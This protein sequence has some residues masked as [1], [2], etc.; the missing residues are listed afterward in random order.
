L[1]LVIV[2]EVTSAKESF[3]KAKDDA[4]NVGFKPAV[5]AIAVTYMIQGNMLPALSLD[6]LGRLIGV[7]FVSVILVSVI[8][9]VALLALFMIHYS[10]SYLGYEIRFDWE[11]VK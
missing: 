10:P 9:F 3:G 5:V 1:R 6:Y 7:L 8:Y 11:R 4:M 2:R